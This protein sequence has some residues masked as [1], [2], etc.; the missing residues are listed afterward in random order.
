M[1]YQSEPT[2]NQWGEKTNT[3]L[4]NGGIACGPEFQPSLT[5]MT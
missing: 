5:Q 3:V 2:V 1:Y 4:N